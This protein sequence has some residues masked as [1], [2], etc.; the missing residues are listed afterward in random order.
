MASVR[1]FMTATDGCSQSIQIRDTLV[2]Q[3][4][5]C[6][7]T[8]VADMKEMDSIEGA[9]STGE[10][11]AV[12]NELGAATSHTDVLRTHFVAVDKVMALLK[13]ELLNT[14]NV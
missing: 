13:D 3:Q 8:S 4:D 2:V 1:S 6:I 10:L 12:F 7:A 5:A 14:S 11:L 9:L